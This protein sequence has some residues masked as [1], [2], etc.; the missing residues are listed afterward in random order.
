M[1]SILFVFALFILSNANGQTEIKDSTS[2]FMFMEVFSKTN[3]G[4]YLYYGNG[5]I[6]HVTPRIEDNEKISFTFMY[7]RAIAETI[8]VLYSQ[9]W[10]LIE[11]SDKGNTD[12]LSVPRYF[13]F[14][15]KGCGG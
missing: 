14:E 9:G 13:Y 8:N 6:E 15:R 10:T 7:S 2:C 12:A 11:V 1:K 4:I 5:S 3:Q